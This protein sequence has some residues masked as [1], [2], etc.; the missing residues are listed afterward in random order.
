MST[1]CLATIHAGVQGVEE[2]LTATEPTSEDLSLCHSSL[3]ER[4]FIRYLKFRC[5]LELHERKQ[6]FVVGLAIS[7]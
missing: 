5:K 4:G 7:L 3:A 2:R 6:N 1:P